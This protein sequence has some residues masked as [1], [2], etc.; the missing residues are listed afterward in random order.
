VAARPRA[1]LTGSITSLGCAFLH[2]TCNNYQTT[3]PNQD[4]NHQRLAKHFQI[5]NHKFKIPA[6]S[7]STPP[8]PFYNNTSVGAR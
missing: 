6:Y 7:H 1:A 8:Q 5:S 3:K 2:S 4:N